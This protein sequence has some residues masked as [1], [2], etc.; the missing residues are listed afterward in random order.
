[1]LKNSKYIFAF[2]IALLVFGCAQQ[3]RFV[4]DNG[5]DSDWSRAKNLFERQRYYRAAQLL[6]D[7]TLNYSGSAFIDSAYLYLG[8]AGFEQGDYFVASDD[9]KRLVQQ[10]PSSPMAGAAA[11]YESRCNYELAPDFRLDQTYTET[12]FTGFQR[13]LE[14]YPQNE[15]A[16][17]AYAYITKCREKLAHKG[18]AAMKLY[19]K[20]EEYAS[21]VIYADALLSD[22]Y[23]TSWA[24]EAAYDKVR[25]LV[26]L[27]E[28]EKA[29][30][31]IADYKR[32]FPTG[33]F[34]DRIE[35]ISRTLNAQQEQ[36]AKP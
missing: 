13:F 32:R 28:N 9:F 17:S 24:D 1:M 20:I 5:A 26:K 14:D 11:F 6:R 33:K 23:D 18:F 2:S 30:A 16:D 25:A 8:R 15:Y 4:T 12:A 22:Y 19:L 21:V 3:T 31:A 27:D 36:A 10:F 34:S 7:I 29:V 35:T